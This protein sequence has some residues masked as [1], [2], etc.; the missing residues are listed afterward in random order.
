[1]EYVLQSKTDLQNIF[2][3]SSVRLMQE[4][5]SP[6]P[7][8]HCAKLMSTQEAGNLLPTTQRSKRAPSVSVHFVQ[9]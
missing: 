8:L 1:M 4:R 6:T 7:T 5:N 3:P 9:I 2:Y